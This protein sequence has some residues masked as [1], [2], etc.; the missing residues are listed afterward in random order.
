MCPCQKINPNGGSSLMNKHP[1]EREAFVKTSR[2]VIYKP[3]QDDFE[4]MNLLQSDP[5]VMRYMGGIRKPEQIRTNLTGMVHHFEKYGF[6]LGPVYELETGQFVG[7]AGI[8]YLGY[9]DSQPDI[10]VGF[11]LLSQFWSKGYATELANA[12]IDWGFSNLK[13]PKLVGVAHVENLKSQKVLKKVNMHYKREGDYQ[14]QKARFYEISKLEW[15]ANLL[16]S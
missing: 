6:S 15:S 2:L 8:L 11:A 1:S 12:L 9:D 4:C 14:G 3:I 7:G 13:I 5:E 16:R 10:E